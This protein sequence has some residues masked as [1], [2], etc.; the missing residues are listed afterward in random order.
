M[1]KMQ[2]QNRAH[3]L[4]LGILQA[5]EGNLIQ[6]DKDRRKRLQSVDQELLE[7]Y[8][9]LEQVQQTTGNAVKY[10]EAYGDEIKKEIRKFSLMEQKSETHKPSKS[11][12]MRMEV[13]LRKALSETNFKVKSRLFLEKWNNVFKMNLGL[14]SW[15]EES[16]TDDTKTADWMQLPTTVSKG[17]IANSYDKLK[18]E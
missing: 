16:D 11:A 4:N 7:A 17:F 10:E 14:D 8:K 6:I 3:K 12:L 13:D 1:T 9:F 5:H 18:A 15:G 2:S